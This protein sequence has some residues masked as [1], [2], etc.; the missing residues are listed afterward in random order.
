[1]RH[2]TLTY[3]LAAV[4]VGGVLAV[5]V[6]AAVHRIISIRQKAARIGTWTRPR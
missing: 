2:S 4:A 6:A 3:A 5:S 1:M